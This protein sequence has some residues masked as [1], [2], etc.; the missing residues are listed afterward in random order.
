MD[1]DVP[2]LIFGPGLPATGARGTVRVSAV[3]VEAAAGEV[4]VRTPLADVNLR[5]VGFDGRGV[6][7]AWNSGSAA[8]AVHVLDGD[9]ARR[10]LSAPVLASTP[11]KKR[12]SLATSSTRMISPV[13][14][15]SPAT[16]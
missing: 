15:T 10:L 11:P 16:P 1:S 7:L 5:A 8:W 6:E 13:R 12:A 4:S 14:T 3:G 9:A 2:A